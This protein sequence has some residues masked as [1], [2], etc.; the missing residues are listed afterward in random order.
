MVT[1]RPG[2]HNACQV[3]E[4]WAIERLRKGLDL[5]LAVLI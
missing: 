5:N 4:K 2:Y 1:P 3:I